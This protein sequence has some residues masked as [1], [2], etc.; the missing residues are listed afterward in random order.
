MRNLFTYLCAALIFIGNCGGILAQ[1][2]K[3]ILSPVAFISSIKEH[4]DVQIIDVRTPE[5]FSTGHLPQA[6]NLNVLESDFNTGISRLEKSRPTYVYCLNGSRSSRVIR[7]MQD[8]GFSEI[9]ELKGGILNWEK[10]GLPI[11]KS[12]VK[13]VEEAYKGLTMGEYKDLLNT[14]KM[15]LVDFW[16]S[17]CAPCREM[18]PFMKEIV[19]TMKDEVKVVRINVA[20]NRKLTDELNVYVLPTLRLFIDKKLVW[21][22]NGGFIGKEEIIKHLH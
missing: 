16:A 11:V 4:N 2:E 18:E 8:L 5:E 22:H 19:E 7:I 10:V 13:S 15:V 14:D 3:V 12:P 20:D 6:I 17:W 1:A 21:T 9:Y